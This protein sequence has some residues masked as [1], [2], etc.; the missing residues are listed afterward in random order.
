M[1]QNDHH[2]KSRNI[3]AGEDVKRESLHSFGENTLINCYNH[4]GDQYGGSLKNLNIQLPC[5]STVPLLGLHPKNTDN[6]K[7]IRAP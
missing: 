3:N 2:E 7:V 5:A 4:F 1:G 6:L